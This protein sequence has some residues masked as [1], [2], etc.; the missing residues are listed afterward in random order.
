MMPMSTLATLAF[1]GAAAA[2]GGY[3]ATRETVAKGSVMAADLMSKMKNET[4]TSMECDPEIPIDHTGA[5]FHCTVRAT[6]GSTA[7]IEYTMNRQGSLAAKLLDT[8][9]ATEPRVPASSDPWSN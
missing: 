3:L 8:T 9:G 6:D 4:L 1:I 2:A 7:R 5:T